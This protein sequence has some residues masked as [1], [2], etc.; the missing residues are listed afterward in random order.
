[1]ILI[2]IDLYSFILIDYPQ[3]EL[4]Y[5]DDTPISGFRSPQKSLFIEKNNSFLYKRYL[6]KDGGAL[7]E[8][9]MGKV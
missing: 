3:L 5:W 7:K 9:R 6:F 1:M 4:D 2:F 8:L